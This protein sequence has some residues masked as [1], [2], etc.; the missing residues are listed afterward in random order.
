MKITDRDRYHNLYGTGKAPYVGYYDQEILGTH[1]GPQ[2]EAP[3]R[4][5]NGYRAS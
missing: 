3:Y 2:V 5:E 4:S 1:R